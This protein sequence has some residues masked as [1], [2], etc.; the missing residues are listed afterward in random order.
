MRSNDCAKFVD[1]AS[2]LLVGRMNI[3]RGLLIGLAVELVIVCAVVM[4]LTYGA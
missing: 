4:L 1:E 2:E 3:A